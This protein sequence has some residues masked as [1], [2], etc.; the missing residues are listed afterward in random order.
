M[1]PDVVAVYP[2]VGWHKRVEQEKAGSAK[3]NRLWI[4]RVHTWWRQRTRKQAPWLSQCHPQPS[5]PAYHPPLLQ[6]AAA[7]D[8]DMADSAVCS[9]LKVCSWQACRPWLDAAS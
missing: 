6:V 4:A 7:I 5:N 2:Q 1:S 8:M 9:A 3:L